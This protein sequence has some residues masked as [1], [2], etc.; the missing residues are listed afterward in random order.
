M[1][2]VAKDLPL[3]EITLRK[4][5]KPYRLDDRELVKKLCLSIGLLQS[6]D[7]RDVVVDVLHAILGDHLEV[8][9]YEIVF[10]LQ[11]SPLSSSQERFLLSTERIIRVSEL[12]SSVLEQTVPPTPI[13]PIDVPIPQSNSVINEALADQADLIGRLDNE[14]AS[15]DSL[16]A[17]VDRRV[18]KI[19][20][21]ILDDPSDVISLSLLAQNVKQLKEDIRRL[22][23]EN[24]RL[25]D[26]L[27]GV[28]GAILIAIVSLVI[29]FFLQQRSRNSPSG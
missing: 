7:S 21:V 5:A 14:V 28:I 3:A 4:Y 18:E 2:R 23:S 1:A 27:Y 6:G 20:N 17:N 11:G 19:E 8:G 9:P 26:L 22:D 24:N 15:I 13:Q 25:F 29:G 12:T 10:M 16:I